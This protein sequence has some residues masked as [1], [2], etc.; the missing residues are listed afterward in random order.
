MYI[1]APAL[2]QETQLVLAASRPAGIQSHSL[3]ADR[4]PKPR[5][6]DAKTT[7]SSPLQAAVPHVNTH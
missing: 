1:E 4:K 7:Q 2:M 6:R 3:Q 5:S